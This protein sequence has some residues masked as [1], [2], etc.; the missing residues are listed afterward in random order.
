MVQSKKR[1]KQVGSL[2]QSESARQLN[3]PGFEEGAAATADPYT[4][5][6]KT[7]NEA[8]KHHTVDVVQRDENS[9]EERA[10]E[11]EEKN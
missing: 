3:N 1:L 11:E 2:S 8:E 5:C 6:T 4:D 7:P 10:Q 9:I